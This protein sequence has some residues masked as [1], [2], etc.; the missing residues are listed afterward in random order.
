LRSCSLQ[1]TLALFPSDPTQCERSVASAEEQEQVMR[2][3]KEPGR[4]VVTI[5]DVA[6]AVG[7]ATSTVSRAL[8]Q[9]D[10]VSRDMRER[11]AAAAAALGYHPNPQARSLTSGRTHSIALLIPDVTNP[12]FFDLI[13]GTQ[14]QAKARGYRHM[15]VDTEESAEVEAA[16]LSEL[17][18]SVDGIVLTGSRLSDEQLVRAAERLPIVV[19]NREIPTIPSVIVDTSAAIGEA[20][21]YLVSLG[22]ART[23]FLAG[24]ASSWSSHRRWEALEG[25]AHR[26][27]VTCVRIGPFS[28]RKQSAAAAAD[29]A[30]HH[31]VTA[32]MFFNDMLAIN[33]LRRFAERGIRVPEDMSVV[34]CDDIFG[35]DFCHPALTTLT[36]PIEQVGRIASD[37][38]L[39]RLQSGGAGP[40]PARHR[41][42]VPA[43]L[44]IRK[45]T[46]TVPLGSVARKS[47]EADL[48]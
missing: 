46:G 38:L 5:A 40:P 24:P 36:A 22:H 14:A 30:I 6:K 17:A 8:T 25:A 41:E 16:M 23:A 39:N 19:V 12:Y 28:P 9:P 48:G 3:R 29:A 13:R 15:L 21:E 42:R 34:G 47:V 1:V 32:C 2:G 10:R 11:V 43:R 7:V 45:S 26:L 35:A 37:M 4:A 20:L 18:G 33:A 44:T 31:G 27:R